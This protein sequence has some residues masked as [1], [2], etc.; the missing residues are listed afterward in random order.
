M[1]TLH[2]EIFQQPECIREFLERETDEVLRIAKEVK[3]QSFDTIFIAAR[4][5]SDNAAR[6]GQYLFGMLNRLPVALAAPSLFT[7]YDAPPRLE[8]ALVIGISQSGQSPDVVRVLEAGR[9]QG[10]ATVAI[11]N[12]PASPL[13]AQAA[14]HI[15]LG[16]GDEK[17]IAA[18]KTYTAQLA[19]LALLALHLGE[20]PAHLELLRAIP[21]LMEAAL[22]GEE[23][24]R[25]SAARLAAFDRAVVI[26]RGFNYATAHE[27]ALKIKELAC[28]EAEPYSS[29][30]FRHG[31]I[32]LAGS[33]LPVVLVSTGD[34]FRGELAE[35]GRSLRERGAPLVKLTDRPEVPANPD[36]HTQTLL[37]PTGI[38]EWLTPLVAILP[39]QMLAY[40]LSL[41]RGF[42]PDQPRAIQK[43][44]R[45]Y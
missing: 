39:G 5:T 19:A 4:G 6:Y 8:H 17:S 27:I 21:D 1:S 29:A 20:M 2:S 26:G 45:T 23:Q 44:T 34:A 24:V 22:S 33:G 32:A 30:D 37:I 42:D 3:Q 9:K 28:V 10:A 43:V 18:T 15:H 36:E 14:H 40:H 25:G 38:P 13:A 11:T 31:P 7:V 12:D 35:L 16:V 41:A